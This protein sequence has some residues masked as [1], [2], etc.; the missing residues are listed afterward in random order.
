MKEKLEIIRINEKMNASTLAKKLGVE[1]SAISHIKSG[2]NNPRY[3]FIVKILE[4]FPHINPDWLLLGRGPYLRSDIEM[5]NSLESD[6]DELLDSVAPLTPEERSLFSVP[7]NI[8][9]SAV[10]VAQKNETPSIF[11]VVQTNGKRVERVVVFYEDKSFE[12]YTPNNP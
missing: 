3:D 1:P 11:P 8:E 12:S 5:F 9:S 4:V 2:R 6:D 7:E 10:N